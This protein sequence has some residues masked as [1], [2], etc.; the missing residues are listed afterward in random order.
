MVDASFKGSW[1]VILT[2]LIALFLS[3]SPLPAWAQWGR[4][5][6]LALILFYWL[7]ALPD[8]VGL[9]LA[10][11]SGLMLDIVEGTHLGQNALALCVMAYLC[12]LLYQRVRMYTPWQQSAVVFVVI[13]LEQLMCNWILAITGTPVPDLQFLLPA[14]S[15]AVLWPIVLVVL[16][17]ARRRFVFS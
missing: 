11:I 8:R 16:R 2:I 12:L 5:E 9:G 3:V 6:F 4:P 17:S 1:I 14:L 13:G 10:W 7:I 15:S